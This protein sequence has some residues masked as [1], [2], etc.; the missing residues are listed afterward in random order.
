M[1][2]EVK[3]PFGN[4][5]RRAMHRTSLAALVAICGTLVSLIATLPAADKANS[6]GKGAKATAKGEGKRAGHLPKTGKSDRHIEIAKV[7][8]ATAERAKLAA[9]RI[10]SLVEA[11]YAKYQIEPN[12]L[13]SDE[14]MRYGLQAFAPNSERTEPAHHGHVHTPRTPRR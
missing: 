5:K 7:D 8:P 12:P 9:A 13:T 4:R 11:N 14:Q 2:G 1:T 10:D 6:A 3:M